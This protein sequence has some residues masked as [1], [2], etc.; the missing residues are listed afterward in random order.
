MYTRNVKNM[1]ATI[2]IYIN[3]KKDVEVN[4]TPDLPREYPQLLHAYGVAKKWLSEN[5]INQ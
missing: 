4:L 3:H 5:L 1:I 2:Q